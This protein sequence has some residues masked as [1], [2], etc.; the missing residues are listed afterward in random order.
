MLHLGVRG[1]FWALFTTEEFIARKFLNMCS[2]ERLSTGWILV[3]E[4]WTTAFFCWMGKVAN[5]PQK[6]PQKTAPFGSWKLQWIVLHFILIRKKNT[7]KF[8]FLP[9]SPTSGTHKCLLIKLRRAMCSGTISPKHRKIIKHL[10]SNI[11]YFNL[12]MKCLG[13]RNIVTLLDLPNLGWNFLSYICSINVELWWKPNSFEYFNMNNNHKTVEAHI[14]FFIVN[15]LK[16]LSHKP[17]TEK[18]IFFFVI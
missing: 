1:H 11:L 15:T 17:T 3:L 18:T 13:Y 4:I 14:L 5:A 10:M 16:L 7:L 8:I 12:A 9:Y 6:Q 2:N